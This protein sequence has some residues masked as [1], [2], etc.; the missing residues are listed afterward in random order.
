MAGTIIQFVLLLMAH[1]AAG[2]FSSTL[3]YSKKTT[4]MIWGAWAVL[5]TGLLFYTEF[6]LTHWA[7]QFFAGFVLSL[8]GQYAIFFATSL[9]ILIS[10]IC[11]LSAILEIPI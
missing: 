7:L 4:Y 6:V 5:Q 8:V 3:K 9:Y 2:I 1:A 11:S 10:N